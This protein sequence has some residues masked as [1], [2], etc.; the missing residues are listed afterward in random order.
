MDEAIALIAAHQFGAFTTAQAFDVGF[1]RASM[2]TRRSRGLWVDLH[3][4][5][6]AI[7]GVPRTWHQDVIAA[8]LASGEGAVAS[9]TAAGT[10]LGITDISWE[11]SM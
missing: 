8:V 4:G 1:T 2:R 9:H 3:L 7:A 6:H 11:S 10:L 5:V